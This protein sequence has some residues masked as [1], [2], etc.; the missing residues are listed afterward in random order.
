MCVFVNR[1]LIPEIKCFF[2]LRLI[3]FHIQVLHKEVDDL[4][5]F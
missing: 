2:L 1:N 4:Y 5:V 3:D